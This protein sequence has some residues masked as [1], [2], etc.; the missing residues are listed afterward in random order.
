MNSSNSFNICPRCGNSNALNAKYCSRCGGQLKVPEE[1]VVCHKCHTHN[2]PMANFCRNCGTALKVGAETKICPR[3]GK[4]VRGEEAICQ[5][6]YSFVTY[7]QTIP[8]TTQAVDVSSLRENA[9]EAPQAQPET[10]V[11]KTKTKKNKEPKVYSKKG[12]RGWAIAG[13]ILVLLFA[14]YIVAPYMLPIGDGF[15][16][17][18]D[19][20]VKLDRGFVTLNADVEGAA[21]LYGYNFVASIVDLVKDIVGGKNIGEAIGEL[22]VGYIIMLALTVIFVLTA[23]IHILVCIIRSFTAKRSKR[24]NWYFLI[25]AILST[26]VTGMF[27]LCVLVK[28]PDGFLS[29]V[30]GWFTIPGSR[31]G[32][33]IWAIPVYFWFFFFYSLCA[34]AKR[35]KEPVIAE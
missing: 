28:M 7:Q 17:R 19:F 34:K 25:M 35:I 31:L 15:A 30:A 16:V 10:K 2:T 32:W 4:E 13:I 22:H 6:G 24:M 9:Q 11:E 8:S 18:P 3:C 14:Y 29:T 5:C 21:P 23:A 20:L 1:P 12:G 26:I 27:L 33:A